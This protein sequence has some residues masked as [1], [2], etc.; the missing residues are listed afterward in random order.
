MLTLDN[1][2]L[3]CGGSGG[4]VNGGVGGRRVGGGG[5]SGS[6]SDCSGGG[7]GG[8]SSGCSGNGNSCEWLWLLFIVVDILFY[9]SRYIILLWCLYYFIVS[10]TKIDPLLQHV[11]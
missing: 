3:S 2:L 9:C 8:G 7:G 10:K 1:Y 11:L 6:D 4:R 5:G